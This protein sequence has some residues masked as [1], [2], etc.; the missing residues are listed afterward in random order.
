MSK[1]EQR[2]RTHSLNLRL[3]PTEYRKLKKRSTKLGFDSIQKY[4]RFMALGVE[5]KHEAE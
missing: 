5:E 1:S 3:S 2:I 4:L